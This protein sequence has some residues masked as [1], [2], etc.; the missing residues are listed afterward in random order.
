MQFYSASNVK[1]LGA[2]ELSGAK[3]LH[4]ANALFPRFSAKVF[5]YL[6]SKDLSVPFYRSIVSILLKLFVTI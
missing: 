4:F 5:L 6:E 2:K 3:N 1:P